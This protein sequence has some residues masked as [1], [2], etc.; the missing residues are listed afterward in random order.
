VLGPRYCPSIESKVI[1]FKEK[2]RHQIWLEPEGYNT[3]WLF[4]LA[5]VFD[6]CQHIVYPNGISMTLPE[7]QQVRFLRTIKGL[8]KVD[9]LVPGVNLASMFF[10]DSQH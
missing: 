3:V 8:E 7:E 4:I 9:M 6:Q 5:F 2:E 10:A 1:R